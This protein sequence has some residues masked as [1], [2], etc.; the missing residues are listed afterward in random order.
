MKKIE[1]IQIAGHSFF[2]EDDAYLLLDNFVK[3]IHRLYEDNAE[4]LKV[5]EVENRIAEMCLAK[6]GEDGIVTNVIINEVISAV[7]IKV[8]ASAA[9]ETATE[10]ADVK[11]DDEQ[12]ATWYKAMLKGSKLFR[13]KHGNILGGVLSGI[14]IHYDVDVTALRVIT[15]VLFVLPLN[16]PVV[17]AYVILWAVLPKATTIMDYTRMRR[18]KECGDSEAVKQTWKRNYDLCVEELSV[19]ADKGC[20]YSFV[21]ILFFILVALMIMPLA[22]VLFVLLF[23]LLLFVLTGWGVFEAFNIPFMMT[24][25]VVAVIAIPVFLLGYF[26]L[27][28]A[29]LC[30]PMK[31]K[32]KKFLAALWVIVLLLVAPVVHRY[33]K[34]NGGYRNIDYIIEYQWDNIKT[35]FSGD[36]KDIALMTGSI[37]YSSGSLYNT[38]YIDSAC[39]AVFASTWDAQCGNGILPLIVESVHDS[40]GK[41]MVTFYTHGDGFIDTQEKLMNEEYDARIDMNFLPD[42]EINGF[43]HFAWDSISRTVY[44]GEGLYNVSDC[45]LQ[46]VKTEELTSKI[47]LRTMGS[48]DSVNFNNASE[49][50]LVPF[51]IFYYGNQRTPSLVVV[52]DDDGVEE[53]ATT[54]KLRGRYN[55]KSGKRVIHNIKIDKDVAE[56]IDEHI[57]VV[58]DAAKGV[59]EATKGVLEVSRDVVDASGEIVGI[60]VDAQK[61]VIDDQKKAIDAQKELL[62]TK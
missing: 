48:L 56:D 57:N 10:S 52:N 2:F 17:L 36:M 18:V 32:T 37:N 49:H 58:F 26:V 1:R 8:E 51:K 3:Q 13:N 30:K 39:D 23:V 14:A 12:N 19:P 50:G 34:D 41:Y 25:G 45:E 22:V 54:M 40:G 29:N 16:I 7:G 28:S 4:E 60:S 62:K 46:R 42:T 38:R 31:S 47:K 61:A 55:R 43:L 6:V 33:I 44:Y 27:N 53:I 24:V 59:L 20:L 21:R 9:E 11:N 15:L 5:A 35:F